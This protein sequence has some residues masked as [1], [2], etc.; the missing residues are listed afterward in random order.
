[1]NDKA[2]TFAHFW[3]NQIA[4]ALSLAT[5][6]SK[7]CSIPM[8]VPEAANAFWLEPDTMSW[9]RLCAFK[10]HVGHF[11]ITDQK[12]DPGFDLLETFRASWGGYV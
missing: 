2:R 9:Q 6:M 3:P 12:S 8:K 7:A 11:H 4:A 5:A 10:G 1:M